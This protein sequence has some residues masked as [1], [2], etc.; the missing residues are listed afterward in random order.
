MQ[1][2]LLDSSLGTINRRSKKTRI[3]NNI[4]YVPVQTNYSVPAKILVSFMAIYII[5]ESIDC[6]KIIQ[7]SKIKKLK[8]TKCEYRRPTMGPNKIFC[9][10]V[11]KFISK[12]IICNLNNIILKTYFNMSYSLKC[13]LH[14]LNCKFK[15]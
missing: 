9:A 2:K 8:Q 13:Y 7:T 10:M 4:P 15:S 3:S 6:W 1:R 14:F 11:G 12:K 5:L